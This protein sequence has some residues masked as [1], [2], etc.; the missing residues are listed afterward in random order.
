MGAIIDILEK[1]E[2]L[3]YKLL[4]WI[5]LIPKTLLQVVL[6]PDWAADYIK[7]ELGEGK[8]KFDEFF[9]PIV[10]LLIVAVLPFLIWNF[11]PVPGIQVTSPATD[12]PSRSR[13]VTFEADVKFISTSTDGHVTTYWRL[14]R[15]YYDEN[16]NFSYEVVGMDR[17]TNNPK[18][19]NS[20]EY[21]GYKQI[22]SHTIQD[23][24]TFEF[25]EPGT[26]RVTIEASKFEADKIDQEGRIIENY[27]SSIDVYVPQEDT[28][29][30][31]VYPNKQPESNK[32]AFESFQKQLQNE[33][34]IFWAFGMFVPPLLFTL[35]IKL[36]SRDMLSEGSLKETFYVQCYYFSPVAFIFWATRYALQ[37]FTPDVFFR[38]DTEG[39]LI[40]LLPML[41]GLLWLVIVETAAF[42]KDAKIPR[43]L[44]LFIVL[45]CMFVIGLGILYVIYQDQ[46][47]VQDWTR[48]SSI[49]LYPLLAI[50][51]LTAFHL[52]SLLKKRKEKSPIST[53]DKVLAGGAF[54]LVFMTL[55]IVLTVFQQDN[56]LTSTQFD[57][58]ERAA[59]VEPQ[60]IQNIR[61]D[62]N[63]QSNNDL[64]SEQFDSPE[65][66]VNWGPYFMTQGDESQVSLAIQDGHLNFKL[67]EIEGQTPLAYLINNVSSFSDVQVE[68]VVKNNNENPSSVSLICRF[69]DKG[70]YEF[71]VT[72]AG[73]YSIYAYDWA[74]TTY[75]ELLSG[76]APVIEQGTEYTVTAI[77]QGNVLTLM[78]NGTPVGVAEDANYT[79]GNIGLAL[80]SPEGKPVDVDFESVIGS[81]PPAAQEGAAT[82]S[83]D[84]SSFENQ[85]DVLAVAAATEAPIEEATTT[86]SSPD[87]FT[88]EF[89]QSLD[90]W[91][92]LG[93]TSQ[94]EQQAENGN[95]YFHLAPKDGQV[96]SVY[97][98]D[99]TSMY[100]NVQVEVVTTNNGNN[101]NGVDLV[102]QA[103]DTGWYEFEV[104]NSGEY[105]I[106][107]WDEI[108][109][110]YT[111][112]LSG[113][114]AT[115]KTGLSQNTYTAVCKGNELTLIINGTPVETITE[116]DFNFME[117]RV[118]FGVSS[119]QGYPVDLFGES[120][121][122]SEP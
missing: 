108:N 6:H 109:R 81:N 36:F 85:Q 58:T 45:G 44:S 52:L 30:V 84:A 120:V 8:S 87:F 50:G 34:T 33:R 9:S 97:F 76:D 19:I 104:S 71:E 62:E 79:E 49:W 119:R 59:Y 69:N 57:A 95:L 56:A 74:N 14:E 65:N 13:T 12:N 93:D 64:F 106:F 105:N 2:N 28:E 27:A 10:L 96:S 4:V 113:S 111:T 103:N 40:V 90:R 86:V 77:C 55:C 92:T 102:C 88:D 118:G 60:A 15:P 98:L 61:S 117:G 37:L 80:Y 24:D 115:V 53:G 54:L 48:K 67:S 23:Y 46:P 66:I 63:P 70:W 41:L 32:F 94:V 43:L 42:S 99:N 22:D 1:F 20:S 35:A 68:T 100:N 91:E 121:T 110:S 29:N 101:S 47:D 116:P 21:Y 31:V 89:D 83:I 38:Y 39:H 18:D 122:V 82:A 16:G 11:L 112:L 75:T 78:I 73:Y 114:S 51:L 26:Y 7:Q 25:S 5:V 107:A 3:I 72:N 17:F